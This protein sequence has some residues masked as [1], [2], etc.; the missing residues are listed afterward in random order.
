M[1]TLSKTTVLVAVSLFL[2][3]LVPMALWPGES[4]HF[5]DVAYVFMTSDLAWLFLGFGAACCILVLFFSFSKYGDIKMGG[6]NAK[7]EYSTFSW[8]SMNMCSALAAGILTLGMCEW[9]SYVTDTPFGVEPY[10]SEAYEWASAYGLFHWGFLAWPILIFP[11]V[12]TGYQYWNGRA[13]T[14]DIQG[15]CVNVINFD[16]LPF[17]GKLLNGLVAFIIAAGFTATIGLGTPIIA[18]LVSDLTGLSYGFEMR[19]ATILGLCVIFLLSASKSI[20]KGMAV[21]SDFNV[22]LAIV[23]I[24]FVFLVG[25]VSFTLNTL[26]QAL[27]INL[28]SFARMATYTD[29]IANTGFPAT[30]TIFYWAW[31]VGDSVLQGLWIAR[32]SKG[33]TIR[34]ICTVLC[35]AAPVACI[36]VFA[37]LS[38][39]GMNLELTGQLMVSDIAIEQGTDAAVLAVLQQMPFPKLAILVFAVLLFFNLATSCVSSSTVVSAL[40]SKAEHGEEPNKWVKVFWACT[41]VT[42]PVALL[43]IDH[44]NE[45]ISL[46]E[47]LQSVTTIIALPMIVIVTLINI[48]FF[49]NLKNDIESKKVLDAIPDS[50]RHRWE[51]YYKEKTELRI[52]DMKN[53]E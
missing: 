31:Y 25:P 22:K 47:L 44:M 28:D 29:P 34:E 43:F 27:G 40:T 53:K 20:S 17:L 18:K 45:G 9:M 4:G 51:I 46:L 2:I 26:V 23:F 16:K 50:K 30:W 8:V 19:I 39:Y 37:V 15:C 10:S 38:Y 48:S 3:T 24:A 7:T 14:L 1:K 12:S 5:L 11:A 36:V 49:K 32:V 13:E 35:V 41:F 52:D 21:I 6:K 42:I 33:R